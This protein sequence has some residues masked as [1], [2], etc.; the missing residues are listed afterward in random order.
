MARLVLDRADVQGP[1]GAIVGDEGEQDVAG[2]EPEAGGIDVDGNQL[3]A[4]VGRQGTLDDREWLAREEEAILQLIQEL[5]P[6]H[7]TRSG[8]LPHGESPASGWVS[9]PSCTLSS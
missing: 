3:P 1:A 8:P 5:G 4:Y 7:T 9:A 6:K 2:G